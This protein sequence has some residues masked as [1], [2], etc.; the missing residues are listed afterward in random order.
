MS[1]ISKKVKKIVGKIVNRFTNTL[2]Q[3]ENRMAGVAAGAREKFTELLTEAGAEGIVL[4]R[5]D[6]TLPLKAD[7][8][9][10]YFGRCQFD[11]FYIGY[12][13]GGDVIA[14][15]K[16]NLVKAL[17]QIG[18]KVY[19]PLK[20]AYSD[21]LALPANEADHGY[22]GNWPYNFDEMPLAPELIEEASEAADTAVIVIGRAAG[23]DREN[24][25]KEGSYYLTQAERDMLDAV[26]AAFGHTVVIM[27]CGNMI[28]MSWT[29][30]YGDKLSAIM[31]V[32]QLGERSGAAVAEVLY[33]VRSPSGKLPMTVARNYSDYP[34]SANFGNRE[35]NNYSE[36]IYV[37]YRYFETFAPDKVLYPFGYGL[38]YTSFAIA[39]ECFEY[40]DGKVLCRARVENT[41]R[42]AGKEVV[43]IYCRPPQGKLGKPLM[44]L[45]AFAKTAELAPGETEVCE[46]TFDEYA[47]ASFDDGGLAGYASAYVLEKGEYEFYIG[48]SVRDVKIA[49][50]F[51]LGECKPLVK[52]EKVMCVDRA[53]AFDVL[54]PAACHDGGLRPAYRKVCV[55]ERD[56]KARICGN[57][58]EAKER[59]AERFDFSEV[60][61][62]RRTVED[63]ADTLSDRELESLTRG[64]GKM[65]SRY[66]VIGNAGAYGG[67]TEALRFRGVPAL[68]T[69]DG[70]AGVRIR[71]TASLLPCGTAIAATWNTALVR[72]LYEADGRE[73]RAIGSDIMLGPGMNIHRN[74]LC[75]RNFEYFSEDPVL[76]GKTAAACVEGLQSGGASACP[77]HFACNNQEV[78]RNYNDSRVS[79]RALREI[80]L[81]GFEICVRESA[82]D[83]I[84]TSYNKI[85]G[86]W[87]HYNYD[88][89]ETVLRNEWGFDGVV[90][91]DWWM[92]R[93]ESPEFEGVKDNAYRVRAGV[94]VLMPGNIR[95][96]PF[97][98]SAIRRLGKEG[99]ITR[100]ELLRTA[101][102]VL[103]LCARKEREKKARS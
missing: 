14:P 29:E 6:G 63:F 44:N 85:N 73:A 81:K 53:D 42:V 36:D 103:K 68:I 39:P 64:E 80:Y 34:S 3:D 21:W 35:F 83:N 15:E 99:G 48:S 20:K 76:S 22:W 17:A 10:A 71:L 54:Y 19:E 7:E 86:V 90:I 8:T 77:K 31:Y 74:P 72:A 56:L 43:Q 69:C 58:F 93:A 67:V 78:N 40:K 4:L 27:N 16:I 30:R 23:E 96:V 49:G 65:N 5:N 41:G 91:T 66:G 60:V 79:E 84:M 100:Y 87:S 45:V 95:G 101:R 1:D 82:P 55:N 51:A 38:S 47:F 26:T 50:S 2:S 12:G 18:V 33:G 92:R 70:P 24:V 37:G 75:G 102:R 46:F 59:P 9:V 94:D 62:G 13:S 28:D 32:W 57:I 98:H 25:L 97:D 11:W 52:L 61:A 88:L 89:A